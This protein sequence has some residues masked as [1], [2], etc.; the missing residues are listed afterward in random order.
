MGRW[1]LWT[2]HPSQRFTWLTNLSPS[3]WAASTTTQ[4]RRSQSYQISQRTTVC[5]KQKLTTP[6][7]IINRS[8][9]KIAKLRQRNRQVAAARDLTLLPSSSHT[10]RGSKS[11]WRKTWYLL[12]T[13]LVVKYQQAALLCAT[14]STEVPKDPHN[15][16]I[17]ATPLQW[18]LQ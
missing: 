1:S 17:W 15:L 4:T 6:T 14:R 13:T 3:Q 10:Y 16:R 7:R 18:T 11:S 8:W 12:K 2:M 5:N 9:L